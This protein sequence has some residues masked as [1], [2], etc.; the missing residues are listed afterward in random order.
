MA[1]DRGYW[2]SIATP[3][4]RVR[5][6]SILNRRINGSPSH[7]QLTRSD[8]IHLHSSYLVYICTA[9]VPNPRRFLLTIEHAPDHTD[10]IT[11]S[12]ICLNPV[13]TRPEAA[14]RTTPQRPAT[15]TDQ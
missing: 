10:L 8:G 1:I 9:L 15:G 13:P 5:V 14:A 4:S 3:I 7:R 6:D 11:E 2:L 12:G